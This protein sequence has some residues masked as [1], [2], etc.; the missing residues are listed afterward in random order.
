MTVKE[1]SISAYV[2]S[3]FFGTMHQRTDFSKS[4]QESHRCI[5]DQQYLLFLMAG[6]CQYKNQIF[7]EHT[8][9]NIFHSG[10]LLNVQKNVIAT[11]SI[12]KP[13]STTTSQWSNIDIKPIVS[14]LLKDS[15]GWCIFQKYEMIDMIVL[16]EKF[17][18]TY[19]KT[20]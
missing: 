8:Y 13:F 10:S 11:S 4:S 19:W 9:V 3:C 2:S 7:P 16:K 18:L 5:S 17:H 12:Q 1:N 20:Y 15:N 6:K 14:A